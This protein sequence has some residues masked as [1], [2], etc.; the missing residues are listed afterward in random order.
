MDA[1]SSLRIGTDRIREI[2]VNEPL[3]ADA[4]TLTPEQASQVAS[5][6]PTEVSA[7]YL[8][9][10]AK[11]YVADK[12]NVSIRSALISQT[13]AASKI[14]RSRKLGRNAADIKRLKR[15]GMYR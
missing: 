5:M 14:S 7:F 13:R 1:L 4:V 2:G 8:E 6:T 15:S 9:L 3:P 11:K 10:L 12:C